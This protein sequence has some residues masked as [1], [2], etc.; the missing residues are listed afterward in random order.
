MA[1]RI[2]ARLRE[3]DIE[4]PEPQDSK[5]AMILPATVA[6]GWLFVSG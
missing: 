2:D 5:V 6:G 1:G 4:L 3:L